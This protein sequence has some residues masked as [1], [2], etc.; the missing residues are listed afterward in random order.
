MVVA[1][2]GPC[3]REEEKRSCW[4]A[5]SRGDK[6]KR[7]TVLQ[8]P[9][10]KDGRRGAPGFG[11]EV[12]LQPLDH[13]ETVWRPAW[14][15]THAGEVCSW[16]TGPCGRDQHLSCLWSTV[17]GEKNSCCRSTWRTI[18]HE[19]DST[20]EQG[21]SVRSPTLEEEGAAEMWW[22]DHNTHSISLHHWKGVGV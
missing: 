12:A 19:R 18:Y 15:G 14:R 9:V 10:K 6:Y 20:S 7:A 4:G 21:R 17:A 3:S 1:P 22:C 5:V 11:A 13:G 2:V 16:R 8:T